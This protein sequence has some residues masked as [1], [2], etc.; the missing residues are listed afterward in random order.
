MESRMSVSLI[1]NGRAARSTPI[2]DT[3]LL[4]VIRDDLGLT[5]TKYG[6][7]IAQ[8]GACTV[9]R[10][11]GAL[12]SCSAP[13]SAIAGRKVTTIEGLSSPAAKAVQKAWVELDVA[14]VRLLPVGPDHVGGG[15]AREDAQADRRRHRPRDGRQHLPLRHLPPHPRRDPR[16][17]DAARCLR[18]AHASLMQLRS[19][20]RSR[21]RR[22]SAARRG[23][24]A[25]TPAL[26][27]RVVLQGAGAAGLVIGF[28]W[29][30][31]G[32]AHAA[33]PRRR[34]RAPPA[35]SRR[36]PS[37]ASA[38]TTSSPSSASTT[39]WARATPPAWPRWSPRSSTPTGR[40]VRTEYA[41]ADAKLYA[42]L[43]VRPLQGTGGSSAIAN[44]FLQYRARRARPRARCWSPPRPR[45]GRCRPRRSRS[46]KSVVSH[47]VGQ[48]RRLRRAADGRGRRSRRPIRSL[49]T[50]AQFTLHRQGPRAPRVDSP[51]K[52]DGTAR[53]THRRQAAGHADGGG[54]AGRRASAR[55]W[56]S[57]DAAEAKKVKGVTDVVQ[58]PEGVAVVATACGPRCRAAMR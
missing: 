23:H 45:P 27:R 47:A 44:S 13:V 58:V 1:V 56:C 15:A 3:P 26:S 18:S 38:P 53:Y 12:R 51:S 48:A 16:R 31:P 40:M 54:R 14:A 28:G 41:P 32:T 2:R 9:H 7:G 20:D 30:A 22:R 21:R 39:R 57:F 25:A 50:P 43:A 49:K 37:C 35:R 10:R 11:R 17:V 6:C 36:T 42:N 46:A 5:G 8:C 52:C 24:A 19:Q 55:R 29:L 4:W 34:G 33:A